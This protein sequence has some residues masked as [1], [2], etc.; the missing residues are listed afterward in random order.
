MTGEIWTL[1]FDDIKKK[2]INA[3]FFICDHGRS[4][5]LLEIICFKDETETHW[6]WFQDNLAESS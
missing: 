3:L 6:D 1:V 2:K 4:P 5:Y